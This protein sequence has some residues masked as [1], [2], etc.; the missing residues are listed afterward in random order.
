MSCRIRHTNNWKH[1]KALICSI[2]SAELK[3]LIGNPDV[4]SGVEDELSRLERFRY[5]CYR[6][7]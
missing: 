2:P 3:S 1:M 7:T 5:D 6:K 4:G